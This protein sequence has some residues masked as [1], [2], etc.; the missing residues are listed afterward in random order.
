MIDILPFDVDPIHLFKH[1]CVS[2][3]AA[4][5]CPFLPAEFI[6][7][8]ECGCMA[9]SSSIIMNTPADAPPSLCDIFSP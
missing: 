3:P 2:H 1:M 4:R 5:S 6:T 7:D 9:L 8:S